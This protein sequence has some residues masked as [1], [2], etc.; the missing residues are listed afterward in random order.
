MC[1][2]LTATAGFS[3][4]L[5]PLMGAISPW[6]H[7]PHELFSN[8][9]TAESFSK[10]LKNVYYSLSETYNR[11]NS[12]LPAQDRLAKTYFS[13]QQGFFLLFYCF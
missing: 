7:V 2:S 8:E 6:A 11:Q 13:T 9:N 12:Y 3:Q 5:S 4:Y 1:L 10:R